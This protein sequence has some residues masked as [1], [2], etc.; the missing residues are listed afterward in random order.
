VSRT[1]WRKNFT[2]VPEK[3]SKDSRE[4]PPFHPTFAR[5]VH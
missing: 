2:W 1:T 3:R 4:F 5:C